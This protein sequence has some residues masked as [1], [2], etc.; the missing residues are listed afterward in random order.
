MSFVWWGGS[1]FGAL[2]PSDSV[3]RV[4][5]AMLSLIIGAQTIM[6]GL[7]LSLLRI[8]VVHPEPEVETTE[9]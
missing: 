1:D 7:F 3:R 2:D 6:A 5:P 8:R 4:M 9:V